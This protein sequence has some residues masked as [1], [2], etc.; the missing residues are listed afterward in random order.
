[1]AVF[2]T[3]GWAR[4]AGFVAGVAAVA[5]LV[6]GWQ[7]GRGTG[8]V[9]ADVTFVAT[10]TGELGLPAGPFVKGIGLEPGADAHGTVPVHNQTGSTLA[11][12]VK[13]LPSIGDLDRVL[14]VR[15]TAG[16]R[17]VYDGPLGG[18]R[19]WSRPF[20]LASGGAVPLGVRIAL[21]DGSD[22]ASHGRI[23]DVSLA[24][25]SVVV[26]SRS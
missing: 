12:S 6:A 8:T 10:P 19:D 26:G 2:G 14:R 11:I 23:D 1:M 24:F 5:I 16:G 9:G 18:L 21:P 15:M 4:I 13:V 7:V 25:R 22:A 3:H 17:E 20:R